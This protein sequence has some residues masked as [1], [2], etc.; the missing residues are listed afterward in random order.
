MRPA[1][2]P[3]SASSRPSPARHAA[4]AHRPRASLRTLDVPEGGTDGRRA[5]RRRL[6][7]RRLCR[8]ARV[9]RRGRRRGRAA[10]SASPGP[11]STPP[12]ARS[13]SRSRC[14]TGSAAAARHRAGAH[15]A[16][17][18]GQ[19]AAVDEGILR[20]TS[21]AS[22]DPAAHFLGRRRLGLDIRD[23]WGRLIPPAGGR[24]RPAAP[25]RR[26]G[27]LRAARNPA[28]DRH[29]VHPAGAGGAG[30]RRQFPLDLPDFNGQVRL[31][32]VGWQGDRVGAAAADSSCATR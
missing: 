2:S 18:L 23:D 10:R 30:R 16:R 6:G 28:E 29:P 5:R 19:L 1:T 17:R 8:R 13:P 26:R 31:M 21:F 32:A 7:T 12:C 20:L 15:G 9:P 4:D 14:P 11:A 27:R 3:R 25:G 24:R 22:P